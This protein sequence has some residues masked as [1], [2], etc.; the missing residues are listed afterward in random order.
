MYKHFCEITGTHP[1]E[2]EFLLAL[3]TA[4]FDELVHAAKA[5][6]V[7][8]STNLLYTKP[9]LLWANQLSKSRR[10]VV[11]EGGDFMITRS[12]MMDTVFGII[13]AIGA[14]GGLGVMYVLTIL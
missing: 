12:A 9:S 10:V 13:T 3:E 8:V 2:K 14:I 5:P 11:A 6:K 1:N 4:T 7:K